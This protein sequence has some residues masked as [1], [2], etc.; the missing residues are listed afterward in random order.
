MDRAQY[1]LDKEDADFDESQGWS[2]TILDTWESMGSLTVNSKTKLYNKD[3]IIRIDS[4]HQGGMSDRIVYV[5]ETYQVSSSRPI[6]D[7]AAVHIDETTGIYA[8]IEGIALPFFLVFKTKWMSGYTPNSDFVP[9]ADEESV[10]DNGNVEINDE[11]LEYILSPIGFP[12][13]TFADVEFSKAQICRVCIKPALRRFFTFFPIV[14]EDGGSVNVQKGGLFDVP[15]P[16]FIE[17]VM[18]YSVVP[19]YTTPGGSVVSPASANPFTFYNEQVMNGTM[20]FGAG[21]AG[22][23]K[24]VRYTGK[25]QPGFVG[26]DQRA[27]WLDKLATQQGYLNYFRREKF[28]KHKVD[29]HW[30]ARGFSTIGGNLNF[31]WLCTSLKWEDVPFELWEPVAIKMAQSNILQQFGMLRQLVKS[32]IAGQLDATVLTNLRKELEDGLKPI[33]DSA[34]VGGQLSLMR[35]GG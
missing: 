10:V 4:G 24:G 30:Y 8:A 16:D 32:D 33:L 11:D 25:M 5:L 22:M 9:F 17:G 21:S 20:G 31:K 18:P 28:S 7:W 2:Q 1:L 34:A 29:G 23:G 14:K 3:S 15:F 13:L 19:Y 35:G 12:F 27:A 26:M 6:I